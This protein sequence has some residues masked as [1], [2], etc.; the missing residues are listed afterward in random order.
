MLEPSP[1]LPFM[2]MTKPAGAKC[3][4]AWQGGEP[5]LLGVDYFR[6][7]VELQRQYADGKTIEN[8][9]Q[10]NGVLLDDDWCDL[11]KD[12]NFLVGLSI[13]GPRDLHDSYRPNKGGGGSFKQV[14][15]GLEHLKKHRIEFNTLTV[16]HRHNS[17]D[18]LRVYR[19]L[20][21]IGSRFQ[22]FIP[23]VERAGT[24]E[25]EAGLRPAQGRGAARAVPRLRG[26]PGLQ[27]G[28]P[29]TPHRHGGRR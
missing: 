12:G 6:R 9:F 20:K 4:L 23:I 17:G 29:E 13:D 19:F 7:V 28:V 21:K 1:G 15:R 2:I 25:T 14:M 22:Q 26:A 5:T 27:R 18:P 3:N 11:F 8:A 10:T 24:M 16:L